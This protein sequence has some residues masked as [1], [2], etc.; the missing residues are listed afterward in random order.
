[1][2]LGNHGDIKNMRLGQGSFSGS[3]LLQTEEWG[4]MLRFLRSY[5][6]W[7]L[8]FGRQTPALP[9]NLLYRSSRKKIILKNEAKFSFETAVPICNAQAITL[10]KAF[11]VIMKLRSAFV[12]T[13][14][15]LP[16]RDALKWTSI[17][18]HWTMEALFTSH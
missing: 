9:R 1:M 13:N 8:F 7:R 10:Q 15:N 11:R 6:M 3:G 16:F 12:L 14:P 4:Y 2:K 17:S 18:L 5:R